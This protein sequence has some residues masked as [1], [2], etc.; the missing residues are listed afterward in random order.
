MS[1]LYRPNHRRLQDRFDTRRLADGV[2]KRV[3]TAEL[4]EDER[5]FIEARD[6]FWVGS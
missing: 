3:V 2:E 5:M 1:R 4:G 6:M